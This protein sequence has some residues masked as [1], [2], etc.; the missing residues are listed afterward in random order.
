LAERCTIQ[1]SYAIGVAR[2][3]PIYADTFGTGQVREEQIE[4][5]VA[6]CMDLTPRGIQTHLGLKKPFYQR[7]AAYGHFGSAPDPDVGFSWER[8]NFVYALKE[9]KLTA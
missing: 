1:F 4:K 9:M 7:A 5:A 2:P 3:L 8:T 6:L